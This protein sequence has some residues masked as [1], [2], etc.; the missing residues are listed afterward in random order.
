MTIPQCK[1]QD[2]LTLAIIAIRRPD[3]DNITSIRGN[4]RLDELRLRV[5][6]VTQLSLTGP[7]ATADK[8]Y[9]ALKTQFRMAYNDGSLNRIL[10][11]SAEA[12]GVGVS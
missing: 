4:G 12:N 3:I 7:Y 2:A 11:S 8:Y 6:M 10:Q 5:R 9:D 1:Q